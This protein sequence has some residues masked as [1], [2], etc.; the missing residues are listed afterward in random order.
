MRIW[1]SLFCAVLLGA[2]ISPAEI[3]TAADPG[4][5]GTW[6]LVSMKSRDEMTGVETDTWGENP[7]GFL[8]YTAGGR[9]SAIL[10][11]ANR[12]I[13]VESAGLA[14]AEQQA[15]LFR[16]FSAYAGRYTLTR[17]G[18]I[19]HVEVAADPTRIGNDQERFTRF[20]GNKLVITTPPIK[21]V[22]S[23]NPLVLHLVWE[24]VE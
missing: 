24:R 2:M 16:T 22:I 13:S 15:M 9:M 5:V 14:T 8:S 11:K 18:V 7:I 17:D 10:A 3:A 4:I 1:P 20:E 23:P 21:N 12:E 6:R 19:H